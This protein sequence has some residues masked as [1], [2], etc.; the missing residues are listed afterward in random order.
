MNKK[1]QSE[2]LRNLIIDAFATAKEKGKENWQTMELGVLKNRILQ[3]TDGQ[4]R[5]SDYGTEL[6]VKLAL[7]YPDV[8]LVT[9]E[10]RPKVTLVSE[11]LLIERSASLNSAQTSGVHSEVDDFEDVADEFQASIDRYRADGDNLGIGE[12]YSS[13][14]PAIS[15]E[16]VEGT[17]VNIV[18][19]WAATGPV[20]AEIKG[21]RDLLRNTD[22]FVQDQLALAVVHATLRLEESGRELPAG[23][24]DVY[25]R[26]APVLR[27]M[28]HL[29][30]KSSP[31]VTA[32]L[33]S[34]KINELVA[35]LATAVERFCQSTATAARLPSTEVVRQLHAYQPFALVGERL[36]LRDVETLLGTMFR[37]F[38]ES[39][40][41]YEAEDISRRARDLNRQLQRTLASLDDD[42]NH[43]IRQ[44]VMKPIALHI[45]SL[46]EEGTQASDQMIAPDIKVVGDVFK[47]DL[48][49]GS[50][51][52][53]FPVRVVNNGDGTAHNVHFHTHTVSQSPALLLAE[54]RSPFD[55]APRSERLI[56]VE[57][58]EFRGKGSTLLVESVIGCETLNGNSLSFPQSLRI[59]QQNTQ[60]NWEELFKNPPYGINPIRRKEDLYGRDSVLADLELL[61]SNE[62]SI[63]LWGQKRVGKTS[64][65]QVLA[66]NLE[67]RSDVACIVLRM[68]ELASLD[69]GQ[70]GHLIGKRLVDKLAIQ[71]VVP[72][73]DEFLSAPRQ[74]GQTHT[75]C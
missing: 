17:F 44:T 45:S 28:L 22:R 59:E 55:L 9:D 26:V 47:L 8:L 51:A 71:E 6:M 73:E 23:V 52:L 7:R 58:I 21:V 74:Y 68:G 12:A 41:K 39:C 57:L 20:D 1:G 24:G 60:P 37:K 67:N 53:V 35:S 10:Q 46:I 13:Q 70:L 34:A 31:K 25:Y 40:E 3:A 65:L 15:E 49:K 42:L 48:E 14:L 33:A 63:F 75:A 64:V 62:S 36:T 43:R 11:E 61:V 27:N 19:R 72:S 66:G 38:C 5:E 4:F 16:D 50:E 29:D 54:P 18:T 2:Q 32:R 69:E 30:R 56:R